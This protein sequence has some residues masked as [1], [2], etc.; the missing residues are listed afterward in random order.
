MKIVEVRTT[1]LAK[2]IDPPVQDA[3]LKQSVRDIILVEIYTDDGVTGTGFI[4][5]L[6]AV[7]NSEA[8]VLKCCMDKSLAP[9]LIGRDPLARE[10]L[11]EEMFRRTTRFGRKGAMIKALSA[12]DIA[13]WDLAGKYA[14]LPVYKLIGYNNP[15][16]RVYGSGGYYS[17]NGDKNDL[18][19][20]IEAAQAYVEAGYPAIKMKV[21]GRSVREDVARVTEVRKAIGDSIP[22]MVDANQNWNLFEALRFCEAVKDLD[23]GFVEEPL[24]PDAFDSY[25]ELSMRTNIPLAAGETENTKYGFLDLIKR[26]GVRVLNND[27][28]R[29]GGVTEWRKATTLAQCYDL[30]VIP[31][32]IQEIHVSL[33]A[34]APNCPMTEYF[35]PDHPIQQFISEFFVEIAPGMKVIDG[36]IHPV[37]VPGLALGYDT[38]LYKKYTVSSTTIR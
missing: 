3:I 21:G 7:N 5:G 18:G 14:K 26:C 35:M 31:H 38:D 19:G 23:I 1:H 37:D 10:Q 9:L 15:N 4:T 22:I 8:P 25:K 2:P 27:V 34:T 13:L 12:I 29:T 17:G 6:G 36:C 20:V 30:P 32:G 33:C 24:P 28:T 16:V 11:W